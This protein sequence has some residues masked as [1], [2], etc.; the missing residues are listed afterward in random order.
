M[1]KASA[2]KFAD[3][4]KK[5]L[6]AKYETMDC[7]DFVEQCMRDVGLKKNLPGSNTWYRYMTWVGTPE[8]CKKKFG[9]IPKGALL[10]ILLN[11]GKEPEKYRGDGIGNASHIGIKTGTG[12]GAIHSSYTLGC[13]AESA[14]KDK[15]I[16]NG[17]WNRIGL[18]DA[19]DYGEKI[20]RILS[21]EGDHQGDDDKDQG[22]EA[23]VKKVISED[24]NPVNM[25]SG[26]GRNYSYIVKVPVGS[27]VETEGTKGDWTKISW[28]GKKG[29]MMSI[30]LSDED[31]QQPEPG[32]DPDDSV[33]QVRKIWLEQLYYELGD[34]LDR[35]G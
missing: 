21:G 11:D 28:K 10:Y 26:P 30:Y 7:Q 19:F 20:N 17:G 1:S 3:A 31:D 18:W 24:G 22:G 13:V 35:R 8:D 34:I 23:A 15:T 9:S 16:P 29:W 5:Y 27:V 12:K 25:R 32:G 6:G 33:V 2:E 14:F 4:G